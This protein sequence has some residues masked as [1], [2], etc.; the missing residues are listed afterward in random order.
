MAWL[1]LKKRYQQLEYYTD[2]HSSH[3]LSCWH[4]QRLHFLPYTLSCL[5]SFKTLIFSFY[6]MFQNLV[7]QYNYWNYQVVCWRKLI[8][9]QQRTFVSLCWMSFINSQGPCRSSFSFASRSQWII[10]TGFLRILGFC[11]IFRWNVRF[12]QVVLLTLNFYTNRYWS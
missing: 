4:L 3:H 11:S 2:R 7:R 12:L 5:S 8:S 6:I 1:I 9:V 10:W